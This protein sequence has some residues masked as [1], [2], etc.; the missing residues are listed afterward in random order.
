L[1]G[2]EIRIRDRLI[3]CVSF[4]HGGDSLKTKKSAIKN[5]IKDGADEVEVTAP[6]SFLKDG[7]WNYVKRELKKV[8]RYAGKNTVRINIESALLTAQEVVRVCTLAADC[9]ITT[10]RTSSGAYNGGF[11]SETLMRVKNAVKDRC[12]IKADGVSGIA[13]MNMAVDIGA[14]IIGCKNATDLARMIL[15]TAEN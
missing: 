7:N 8:K 1:V 2:S 14:G 10:L 12:V 11:D 3:A 5:A 6:I 9:G 4:P 15:Q 13:E